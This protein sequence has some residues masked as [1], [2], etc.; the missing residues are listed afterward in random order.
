M[1]QATTSN[2]PDLFPASQYR[3]PGTRPG[4]TSSRSRDDRLRNDGMYPG[5][6]QL[7]Q[8]ARWSNIYDERLVYPSDGELGSLQ[9][10]W[11]SWATEQQLRRASWAVLIRDVSL[12]RHCFEST[13]RQKVGLMSRD[14]ICQLPSSAMLSSYLTFPSHYRATL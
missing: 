12:T 6:T 11:R 3:M 10:K 8:V 14:P 7:I 2:P 13:M 5:S 9:A 4:A 1:H